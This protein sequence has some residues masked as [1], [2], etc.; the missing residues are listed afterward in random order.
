MCYT[1]WQYLEILSHNI[2]RYYDN[3]DSIITYFQ[4]ETY[5]YKDHGIIMCEITGYF[6]SIPC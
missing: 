3:L 1:Q 6:N 5:S 2:E 4:H